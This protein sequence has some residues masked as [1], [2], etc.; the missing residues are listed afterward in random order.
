MD[1]FNNPDIE[2]DF[3]LFILCYIF[4]Y[5]L[6]QILNEMPEIY[7]DDPRARASW[8]TKKLAKNCE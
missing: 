4:A 1:I 2:P 8:L 5:V 6:P 7:Q 3:K